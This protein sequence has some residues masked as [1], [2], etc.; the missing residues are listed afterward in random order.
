MFFLGSVSGFFI[1]SHFDISMWWMII[2]TFIGV[3]IDI[4]IAHKKEE[5]DRY[6]NMSIS[7]REKFNRNSKIEQILK[8][9]K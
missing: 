5:K 4:I 1:C 9:M 8:E 2:P 3:V 6:Y 7:E